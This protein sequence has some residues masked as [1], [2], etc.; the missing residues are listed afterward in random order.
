MESHTAKLD[1]DYLNQ[2]PT[3]LSKKEKKKLKESK[4]LKNKKLDADKVSI[5][6]MAGMNKK[7]NFSSPPGPGHERD[8]IRDQRE[9]EEKEKVFVLSK[10]FTMRTGDFFTPQ[11]FHEIKV[12]SSRN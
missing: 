10:S 12:Y 4:K 7:F 11:Q 9:E 1:Q 6:K 5:Q 2:T 8:E 3:K